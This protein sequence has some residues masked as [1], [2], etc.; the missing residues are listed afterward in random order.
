MSEPSKKAMEAARKFYSP[1]SDYDP[2]FVREMAV[3]LDAFAADAARGSAPNYSALKT[4]TR[5]NH[6]H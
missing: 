6:D 2:V 3:L 5:A 4:N 1:Q